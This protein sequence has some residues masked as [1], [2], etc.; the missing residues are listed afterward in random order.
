MTTR[1]DILK[2]AML[3]PWLS[4][5]GGSSP[6]TGTITGARANTESVVTSTIAPDDWLT[7]TPES[8][9]ISTAA[10]QTL[11]DDGAKIPA[12]FSMLVVRNGLL[13]GERYYSGAQSSDLRHIRSATKTVSSLLVGQ[14]L[15]DRKIN[16]TSDTLRT[17]LPKELAKVPNSVAGGITLG[18]ILQMRSGQLWDESTHMQD[19]FK[20]PDL[21]KFALG[22]PADGRPAGTVWNYNSAASHLVSPI[23]GAAYG[24][25]EISVANSN[26]FVPM[27][28]K[29]AAWSSDA[30]AVNH[31]S[32][33]LQ[34]RT[35]DLMKLAWMSLDGGQWEGR[36]IVPSNWLSESHASH[37]K[38]GS[39]GGMSDIGYGNLW[40]TGKLGGQSVILAWGFG[41]Q[42]AL[43]VPALRITVATSALWNI[44]YAEGDANAT[45]IHDLIGRFIAA[46]T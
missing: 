26:L 9:G 46:V 3:A 8:Q 30:S 10:M 29:Q 4:A 33:G 32:F 22:L 25:D 14:A 21:S 43:L 15:R 13:V 39:D 7:G 1:R 42:F 37:A 24:M 44:P 5:C 36:S 18:Q 23:L 6:S 19:I 27:G 20:A 31:G 28:I 11:L 16:S 2:L 45:R 17:L 34:L 35:R 41:G 38:L 12:L 40:W